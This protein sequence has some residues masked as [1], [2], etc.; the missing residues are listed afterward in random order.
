LDLLLVFFSGFPALIY[1]IVWERALFALYGVN[2]ESVTV[3]VTGFLLGLGLG[4]L[5]GGYLSRIAGLPLLALFGTAELCTAAY[6][7]VSLRLFHAVGVYTA[8][9]SLVGTTAI[10]FTLLLIPTMLMG[11]TLPMLVAYSVGR[12]RNVGGS[13]GLLYFVKTLGSATACFLA[14]AVVMALLGEFG[15]VALGAAI[16]ATVGIGA[17]AINYLRPEASR[18]P[19]T[20]Q[21]PAATPVGGGSAAMLSQ[22]WATIFVGVLGFIAL[23]YEILWYRLFSFWS[24]SGARVFALLLGAYLAGIAAGGLIAHDLTSNPASVRNKRQY[25][26]LLASFVV[27]A[28]VAGFVAAPAM[29]V[30]AQYFSASFVM[31]I[32]AFVAALLATTFPLISHLTI[33]NDRGAGYGASWLYFSNI[34]GSALGSFVVG[35][36]LMNFWGVPEISVFLVLA[37]LALG[38]GLIAASQ[39]SR[40]EL[41]SA[42][43]GA[44]LV[45]VAVLVLA[46]PLFNSLYQKNCC[47]RPTIVRS[48]AFAIW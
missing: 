5:V 47:S 39:P 8:G 31:L 34:V 33:V 42:L 24:G 18:E 30:A 14:E 15:S 48:R 19:T 35:F 22:G 38:I 37:G 25:L 44:G 2:I 21:S 17:I 11:A 4:S 7:V 12:S 23:A 1:Q 3:V 9:I 6:G 36:V 27:L 45:C 46:G 43:A 16:N 32:V 26:R 20:A 41:R 13:L 10:S 29:G 28:N 40:R